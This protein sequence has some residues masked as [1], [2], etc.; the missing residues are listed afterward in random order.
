[1]LRLQAN[2]CLLRYAKDS[3]YHYV[4]NGVALVKVTNHE[5]ALVKV[6]NHGMALVKVANHEWL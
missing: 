4:K 6:T 5:M 3:F 2:N 1:M